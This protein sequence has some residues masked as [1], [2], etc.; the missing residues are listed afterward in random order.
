[1]SAL[2]AELFAGERRIA[3]PTCPQREYSSA[4]RALTQLFRPK[5]AELFVFLSALVF[6]DV[7]R[8][9][10]DIPRKRGSIRLDGERS[11]SSNRL[12]YLLCAEREE[13]EYG[14]EKNVPV[15]PS[16]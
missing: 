11:L 6:G 3:F 1:M 8:R 2:G 16:D 13:D 7:W 15:P 10:I 12:T 9:K 5:K 4:R 14:H